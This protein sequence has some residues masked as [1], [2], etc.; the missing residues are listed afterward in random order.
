MRTN[1]G[2]EVYRRMLYILI[3]KK[4]IK[5]RI[6]DA[7]CKLHLPKIFTNHN[8]P[9]DEIYDKHVKLID[10]ME[11]HID[12]L[13]DEIAEGFAVD[14]LSLYKVIVHYSHAKTAK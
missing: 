12:K 3:S 4:D 6:I 2:A 11:R 5:E 13:T 1:Y 14:I 10:E 8:F 9:K 7:Y